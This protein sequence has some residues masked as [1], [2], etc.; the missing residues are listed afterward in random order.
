[1]TVPQY[2]ITVDSLNPG[3]EGLES[4]SVFA[5]TT[6]DLFADA[7]QLRHCLDCSASHATK[8]AVALSLIGEIMQTRRSG[9]PFSEPMRQLLA[10][11]RIATETSA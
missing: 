8:L 10:S 7:N 5:A 4:V 9:A 2:R 6:H 1:M 11:V 3:E